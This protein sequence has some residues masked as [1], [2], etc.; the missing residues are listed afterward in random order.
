G[1]SRQ[2]IHGGDGIAGEWA[3]TLGAVAHLGTGYGFAVLGDAGV[4]PVWITGEEAH[5]VENVGAQGHHVFPTAALVLLAPRPDLQQV[6]D[7]TGG[8]Q[9]ADDGQARAVARLVA[10][11]GLH[12]GAVA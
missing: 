1:A 11:G 5:Q 7:A 4:A 3:D 12:A 2:A 10:D 6:A 8:D 9:L